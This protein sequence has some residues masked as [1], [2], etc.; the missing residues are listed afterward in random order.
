MPAASPVIVEK[1]SRPGATLLDIFSGCVV[2][3]HQDGMDAD[4]V[5]KYTRY[6]IAYP[7]MFSSKGLTFHLTI[8]VKA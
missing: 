3:L 5:K 4:H 1:K 2:C 7:F 6:I 8:P